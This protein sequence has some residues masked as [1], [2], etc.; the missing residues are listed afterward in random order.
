[1][2]DNLLSDENNNKRVSYKK[3]SEPNET[4][5]TTLISLGYNEA[6][7]RKVFLFLKPNNLHKAID[8]M[9]EKEGVI[10]HFF[11]QSVIRN[12]DKLC[13][14]CGKE[15]NQHLQMKRKNFPKISSQ[16]ESLFIGDDENNDII[17]NTNNDSDEKKLSEE[18]C[19]ICFGDI[20]E[21]DKSRALKCGHLC[22][23]ACLYEYIK[24]IIE[25]AKVSAIH[26]FSHKCKEIF[27]EN[28]IIELIKNN[29]KLLDKYNKFKQNAEIILCPNKKFCP[30]PNCSSYIERK[31]NEDKYVKC[32]NGHKFC[33]VC[34]KPWHKDTECDEELDKDFQIWK[35][36]KI[37]KQCPMC[38]FYT[39]KNM[40]CN[41]M[42]CAECGYQWC[43]LCEG[44]YTLDHY[45]IGQCQGKQ[46]LYVD[47]GEILPIYIAPNPYQDA[48]LE[49]WLNKDITRCCFQGTS[50]CVSYLLLYLFV[51][52]VSVPLIMFAMYMVL[53][54]DTNLKWCK[55]FINFIFVCILLFITVSLQLTATCVTFAYTVISIIVPPYHPI[56]LIKQYKNGEDRSQYLIP[57]RP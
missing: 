52:F 24:G 39:E 46:F 25:S 18:K 1:M 22:C 21:E 47:K 42:T 12:N 16:Y 19:L 36:G 48:F 5:I 51:Y 2:E 34:L 13:Y 44:Q 55:G 43:W 49:E 3:E 54:D 57:N 23:Y 6:L 27:T 28:F 53:F 31:P 29:K 8:L 14:V 9:T 30:Q 50:D 15:Y 40:G 20:T 7:V 45:Q 56:A 26:C 33:F 38:R 17:L 37:I 4:D 41:H 10:Q 32:K 35:K 11:Y